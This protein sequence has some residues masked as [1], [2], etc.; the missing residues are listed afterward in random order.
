MPF[1]PSVSVSV[2]GGSITIVA[3]GNP[4][5]TPTAGAVVFDENTGSLLVGTSSGWFPPWSTAW[6]VV[7]E[8]EYGLTN[9]TV[10]PGS[11]TDLTGLSV[12][13]DVVPRRW[14]KVTAQLH[15]YQSTTAGV[16]GVRIDNPN[17][18]ARFG[19]R[20]DHTFSALVAQEAFAA[21]AFVQ[22]PA[23][24]AEVVKVQLAILT[25]GDATVY[26][27]V[28]NASLVI[29]DAGPAGAPL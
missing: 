4:L 9:Q 10:T 2:S 8:V 15:A 20:H 17:T 14:Y 23:A 7:A 29:E 27:N 3:A 19:G 13:L 24:A 22:W 11:F 12:A 6:G 26:N 1:S 16:V 28:Q 18:S 21:T 25:G 5:P